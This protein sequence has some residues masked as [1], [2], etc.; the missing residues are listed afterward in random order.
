[1]QPGLESFQ[2]ICNR[3]L[4]VQGFISQLFLTFQCRDNDPMPNLEE[5]SDPYILPLI[6]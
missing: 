5:P 4:P 1:M 6:E 3:R 2:K